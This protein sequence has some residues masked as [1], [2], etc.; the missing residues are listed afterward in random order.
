MRN[1]WSLATSGP[2]Y[3]KRR[4]DTDDVYLGDLRREALC[5]GQLCDVSDA[6]CS[7]L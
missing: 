3:K 4:V 2:L 7:Y 1:Y 6:V 5:G